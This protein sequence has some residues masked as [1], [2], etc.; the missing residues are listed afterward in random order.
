MQG[1]NI[2]KIEC[3]GLAMTPRVSFH[4][5]RRATYSFRVVNESVEPF[6][7]VSGQFVVE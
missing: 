4:P 3:E 2:G 5:M 6:K 7:E 1:R